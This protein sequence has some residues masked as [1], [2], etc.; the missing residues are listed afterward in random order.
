MYTFYYRHV[1]NKQIVYRYMSLTILFHL[2][3][4]DIFLINSH[5]TKLKICITDNWYGSS[6]IVQ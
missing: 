1:Y 5:L 2:T 3:I 6:K 4:L